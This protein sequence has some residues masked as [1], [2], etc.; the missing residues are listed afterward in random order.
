MT[1]TCQA[2]LLKLKS[3][4]L[5]IRCVTYKAD[6]LK[7]LAVIHKTLLDI[8]SKLQAD[9]SEVCGMHAPT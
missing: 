2:T 3:V 4:E 6:D 7:A 8:N 1:A 5:Y 9:I